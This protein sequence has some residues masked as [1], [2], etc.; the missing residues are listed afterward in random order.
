VHTQKK[1]RIEIALCE[2]LKE[3][4]I[5]D[6]IEIIPSI[7]PHLTVGAMLNEC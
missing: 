6:D 3:I 5:V 4:L 2:D 7:V 1:H